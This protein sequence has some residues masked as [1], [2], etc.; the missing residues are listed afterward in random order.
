MR[1]IILE[2]STTPT[3]RI[4][5]KV[6]SYNSIA[7]SR[8]KLVKDLGKLRPTW[9][10]YWRD[11]VQRRAS[12]NPGNRT[13]L[14]RVRCNQ[15]TLN[16]PSHCWRSWGLLKV[17][18]AGQDYLCDRRMNSVSKRLLH[19][20]QSLPQRDQDFLL[21]TGIAL[22]VLH[23]KASLPCRLFSYQDLR[24]SQIHLRAAAQIRRLNSKKCWT[25]HQAMIHHHRRKGK[26]R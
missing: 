19:M 22:I 17:D 5:P 11:R 21:T 26:A 25:S 7:E 8:S 16:D 2:I 18:W 23:F 14:Q 10:P 12:F 20:L 3:A 24:E 6:S 4:L 1:R 15:S 13:F 9:L